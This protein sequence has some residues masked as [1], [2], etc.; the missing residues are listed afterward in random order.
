MAQDCLKLLILLIPDKEIDYNVDV[1]LVI[2]QFNN[3][4]AIG[5]STVTY[6]IFKTRTPTC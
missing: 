5:A 4:Q 2:N 6:I 1:D 3:L